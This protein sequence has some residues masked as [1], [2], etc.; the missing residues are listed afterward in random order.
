MD[1]TGTH[2]GGEPG[3][4][5]KIHKEAEEMSEKGS[6]SSG[7]KDLKREEEG[8]GPLKSVQTKVLQVIDGSDAGSMIN[9][10]G[11]SW[12]KCAALLLGEVR[13]RFLRISQRKEALE[14]IP[15]TFD[16][17]HLVRLP[18]HPRRPIQF[19]RT[20]HGRWNPHHP[21]SRSRHPLHLAHTLEI[22][23]AA[24]GPTLHRRHWRPRIRAQS[25]WFLPHCFR[26][27]CHR[28]AA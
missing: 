3:A 6:K 28:L 9:L 1:P 21:R 10:K 24:S 5:L 14:K 17:P 20:R 4:V 26:V 25:R 11:L 2:G 22:L 7:E 19:R 23:H 13:V 8:G 15:L 12:Q 16:S 27:H 18:R